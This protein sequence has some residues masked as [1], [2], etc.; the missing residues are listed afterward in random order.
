VRVAIA[1][2]SALFRAGLRRILEAAG[3]EVSGEASDGNALLRRVGEDPPDVA[4]V[5]IRMPPTRTYEGL[6]VAA[7]IRRRHP[8]VG[9][10]VLSS[11]VEAE[12]AYELLSEGHRGSGYL[13]KDRVSDEDELFDALERLAGGGSVVDPEVVS[14]LVRMPRTESPMPQLTERER[15][16]LSLMAEGRS[17]Q[18]IA[19]RLFL[20][21]RTVESNVS[22]IFAKLGLLPAED[23][24]RRVLAVLT[25][26][27][28][29][30][31]SQGA[32]SP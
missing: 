26:L 1:D 23:D 4:I 7:E 28:D 16:I 13:L 27:R 30:L 3:I 8:N 18:A 15:E 11:Y 12:F 2:D 24:H 22:R 20:S 14:M 29:G 9:V 5:D 10:L 6:E 19:Q 17:N 25:Y 21:E 32:G 31:P